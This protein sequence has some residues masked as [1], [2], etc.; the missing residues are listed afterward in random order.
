MDSLGKI[1]ANPT[2]NIDFGDT[3]DRYDT[4]ISVQPRPFSNK[5]TIEIS[6]Q[7]SITLFGMIPTK[8]LKHMHLSNLLCQ[9]AQNTGLLP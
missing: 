1:M 3:F 7:L 4:D 2:V 9:M 8:H 5:K 6:S